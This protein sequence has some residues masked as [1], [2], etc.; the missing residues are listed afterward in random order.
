MPDRSDL[1]YRW[2]LVGLDAIDA[3]EMRELVFY[4]LRMVLRKR[5]AAPYLDLGP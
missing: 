5:V 1:R 4:A 3:L 2:V